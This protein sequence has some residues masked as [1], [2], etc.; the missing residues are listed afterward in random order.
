KRLRPCPRKA[1]A[2][3]ES[4]LPTLP[5]FPSSVKEKGLTTD[6]KASACWSEMK[7][8]PGISRQPDE[9]RPSE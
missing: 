3:T 8:L 7:K 2:G 1:S 6:K 5:S 9:K 4:P